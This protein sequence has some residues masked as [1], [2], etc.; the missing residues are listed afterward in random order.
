MYKTGIKLCTLVIMSTLIVVVEHDIDENELKQIANQI[1]GHLSYHTHT[2]VISEEPYSCVRLPYR[3]NGYG[4]IHRT[5]SHDDYDFSYDDRYKL[6]EIRSI[7]TYRS[8]EL[9]NI[10]DESKILHILREHGIFDYY[11]MYSDNP[12]NIDGGIFEHVENNSVED[13]LLHELCYH[14]GDGELYQTGLVHAFEANKAKREF[15]EWL[16]TVMPQ[17]WYYDQ[18]WNYVSY[19]AATESTIRLCENPKTL[20]MFPAEMKD[21]IEKNRAYIVAAMVCSKTGVKDSEGREYVCIEDIITRIRG[22]KLSRLLFH[23]YLRYESEYTEELDWHPTVTLVPGDIAEIGVS[24]WYHMLDETSLCYVSSDEK[25]D[26]F[27]ERSLRLSS[28]YEEL[29]RDWQELYKS[30]NEGYNANIVFPR[31]KEYMS[32]DDDSQYYYKL[33]GE[34]EIIIQ[35]TGKGDELKNEND[36]IK[37]QGPIEMEE[38]PEVQFKDEY[39][40]NLMLSFDRYTDCVSVFHGDEE[41][42]HR[43][44]SVFE[45][46]R[47]DGKYDEKRMNEIENESSD[48]E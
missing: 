24:F 16:D 7:P 41:A 20:T 40:N 2:I 18:N 42:I 28:K 12:F 13:D 1:G 17:S 32:S 47:R 14:H 23:K 45:C 3:R 30:M 10:E 33:N 48:N 31:F 38:L 34:N 8:I 44:W 27:Y 15:I 11:D 22:I 9:V 43:I 39:G 36:E 37:W 26:V 5:R 25:K 4:I 21:K 19:L 29:D 6:D 35:E 46:I